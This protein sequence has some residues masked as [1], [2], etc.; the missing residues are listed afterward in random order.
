LRTI[1]PA[2]TLAAETPTLA[3]RIVT[4]DEARLRAIYRALYLACIWLLLADR[5]RLFLPLLPDSIAGWNLWA[6]PLPRAT[7][8]RSIAVGIAVSGALFAG[9]L[10]WRGYRTWRRSLLLCSMLIGCCAGYGIDR[11]GGALVAVPLSLAAQWLLAHLVWAFTTGLAERALRYLLGIVTFCVLGWLIFLPLLWLAGVLLLSGVPGIGSF[12]VRPSIGGFTI[13]FTLPVWPLLTRRPE[14]LFL[15]GRRLLYLLGVIVIGLSLAG[16]RGI[17]TEELG[18]ADED[19][20]LALYL[21]CFW[22]LFA[23]H[24]GRA[25]ALRATAPAE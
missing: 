16:W 22:G 4:L 18:I 21:C 12:A 3:E 7:V 10:T 24:Q 2:A 9:P 19:L 23:W 6:G 17:A 14:G 15:W 5:L 20:V 8:E 13:L 11:L 25:A 1:G